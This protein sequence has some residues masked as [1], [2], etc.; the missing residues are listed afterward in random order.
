MM[1]TPTTMML[2]IIISDGASFYLRMGK[3]DKQCTVSIYVYNKNSKSIAKPLSV[4]LPVPLFEPH[5]QPF[6]LQH[7]FQLLRWTVPR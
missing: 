4:I 1:T 6:V 3:K 2:L 5:V 7:N